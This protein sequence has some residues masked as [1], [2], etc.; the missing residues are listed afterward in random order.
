MVLLLFQ[1]M[2]MTFSLKTE[3]SN[4][5]LIGMRR[6]MWRTWPGVHRGALRMLNYLFFF[7]IIDAACVKMTLKVEAAHFSLRFSHRY[8]QSNLMQPLSKQLINGVI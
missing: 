3:V 4:S 6:E 8:N 1:Q 5:K 7:L 2:Q